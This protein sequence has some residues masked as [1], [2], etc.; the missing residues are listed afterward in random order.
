MQP[1]WLGQEVFGIEISASLC[2]FPAGGRVVTALQ[3]GVATS[4]PSDQLLP[5][6]GT[7]CLQHE[8]R[9]IISGLSVRKQGSKR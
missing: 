8:V 3:H 2:G 7:D 4:S 9:I 6:N 5:L 1:R